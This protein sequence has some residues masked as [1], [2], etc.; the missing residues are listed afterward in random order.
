MSKDQDH[1][2]I[3]C[4]R[5]AFAWG[6]KQLAQAQEQGKISS[7]SIAT[8]VKDAVL[9]YKQLDE[10]LEYYAPPPFKLGWV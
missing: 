3:K 1:P 5:E 8:D 6:E 9:L 10:D 2:F 7:S 4:E